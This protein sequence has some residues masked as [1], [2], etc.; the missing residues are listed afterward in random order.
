M[1]CFEA[2]PENRPT[3]LEIIETA[4]DVRFNLQRVTKT[5]QGKGPEKQ[6]E[7]KYEPA[8]R[9]LPTKMRY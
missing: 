8:R 7:A 3:A 4:E 1:Q 2:V 6:L 9:S 5:E